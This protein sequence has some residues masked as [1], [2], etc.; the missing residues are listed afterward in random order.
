VIETGNT[1]DVRRLKIVA[2]EYSTT[3]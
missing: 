2:H 1:K 3:V